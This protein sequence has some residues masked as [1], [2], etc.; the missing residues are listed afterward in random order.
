[1]IHPQS[2]VHS[3]VVYRDGSVVAQM[4]PPDM[5]LPIQYALSYPERLPSD[6]PAFDPAT[7]S[8]LTFEEPD[9]ER[10]PSL[11]LGYRA[12]KGGGLLG[13]VL[14]AA[15]ER[16]VDLFLAGEIA[17]P[18]IFERVRAALAEFRDPGEVTLDAVLEAD[19]WAREEVGSPS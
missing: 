6:R 13:A 5:R 17:F 3:M 9:L 10:F 2:V 7:F 16:A 4:G 11:E 19:R 8:G 1:V 14:N 12:A 18:E 15:N